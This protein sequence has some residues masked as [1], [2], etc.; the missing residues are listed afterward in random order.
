MQ[1]RLAGWIE[2]NI[3]D[4]RC[5]L[6]LLAHGNRQVFLLLP[7]EIVQFCVAERA[8]GRELSRRDAG[9]FPRKGGEAAAVK[10]SMRPA[11]DPGRVGRGDDPGEGE[12]RQ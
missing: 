12:A 11:R 5:N 6:D 10:W 8:D 7:I 4:E 2:R 3:A 1:G 9:P